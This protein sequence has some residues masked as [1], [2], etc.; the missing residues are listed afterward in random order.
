MSCCVWK[1][2]EIQKQNKNQ[3]IHAHWITQRT[4][5]TTATTTKTNISRALGGHFDKIKNTLKKIEA[6]FQAFNRTCKPKQTTND[7]LNYHQWTTNYVENHNKWTSIS[8][9]EISLRWH[10]V[11]E[12]KWRYNEN[13]KIVIL[14]KTNKNIP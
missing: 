13:Q 1:K 6:H 2:V 10:K 11:L 9:Q 4:D 5:K 14:H 7:V 8:L 3:K 12:C